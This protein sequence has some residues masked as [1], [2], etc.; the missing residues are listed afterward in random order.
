MPEPVLDTVALRVMAFA[1]PRGIGVLLTALG[2][3]RA[4]FPTE[5]YNNDEDAAPLERG[6]AGFSELAAGLRFARRE[7]LSRPAAQARRYLTWL[8]NAAQLPDRLAQGTLVV[9]PLEVGELPQREELR[10]RFGIG[11]GEAACLVLAQRHGAEVVFLSSDEDACDAAA[12]LGLAYLTLKD[13]LTAWV[14]GAPP[15]V[16]ELDAMV[17]GMRLAK[18]GLP[19]PFV[20]ELRGQARP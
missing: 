2:V 8:R 14:R 11:R 20:E 4:R 1:H 6:D 3:P 17:E 5:V 7:A 15:T 16:A 19:P 18:F 12:E 10:E 13:V 9:D